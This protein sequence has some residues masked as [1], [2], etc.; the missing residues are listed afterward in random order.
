VYIGKWKLHIPMY[1]YRYTSTKGYILTVI[2]P[3]APPQEESFA[4]II[5]WCID[6]TI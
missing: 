2:N 6:A 5:V 3:N 4:I 1:I